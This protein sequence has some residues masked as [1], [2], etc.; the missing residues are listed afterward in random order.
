MSN[1][2]SF[3]ELSIYFITSVVYE[4]TDWEVS[5]KFSATP[6]NT[7]TSRGKCPSIPD[8]NNDPFLVAIV[9][10]LRKWKQN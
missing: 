7:P 6:R 10:A 2:K 1:S 4:N 5:R 8:S 9:T 3:V